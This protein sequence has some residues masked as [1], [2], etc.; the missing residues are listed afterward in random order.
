MPLPVHREKPAAAKHPRETT[1]GAK[2]PFDLI[3]GALVPAKE[4]MDRSRLENAFHEGS[5]EV[6]LCACGM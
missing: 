1:V 5:P 3:P 6:V 2:S 4:K